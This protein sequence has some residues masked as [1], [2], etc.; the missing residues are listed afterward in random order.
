MVSK[1]RAGGGR[2]KHEGSS[3][4]EKVMM[5]VLYILFLSFF[6]SYKKVLTNPVVQ[7][8]SNRKIISPIKQIYCSG[9]S[10]VYR[11]IGYKHMTF[12]QHKYV[13]HPIYNPL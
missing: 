12:I 1:G 10:D 5:I 4:R 2:Y 9:S 7:K 6:F 11:V 3:M 13:C 8:P